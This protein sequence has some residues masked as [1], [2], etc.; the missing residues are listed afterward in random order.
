MTW[1][2][3]VIEDPGDMER[4][5]AP[6]DAAAARVDGSAFARPAFAL[7]YGAAFVPAPRGLVL[8]VPAATASH[9]GPA[10]RAARPARARLDDVRQRPRAR[11]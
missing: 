1:Q 4:L 10:A 11:R 7:A 9:G 3:D 6:W 2:W 8:S 5:A